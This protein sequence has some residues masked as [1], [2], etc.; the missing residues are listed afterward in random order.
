M[1]RLPRPPRRLDLTAFGLA[2]AIILA[3]AAAVKAFNT[4]LDG[5]MIYENAAV[6]RADG[7][8]VH[9]TRQ[10]LGDLLRQELQ[11]VTA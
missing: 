8:S 9:E 11:A 5:Y 6:L 10:G 2:V 7:D 3:G 1:T 4:G